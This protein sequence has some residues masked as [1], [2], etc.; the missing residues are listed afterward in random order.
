[1]RV[2]PGVS[3]PTPLNDVI[4]GYLGVISA[5]APKTKRVIM[6]GDSAG[7]NLVCACVNFLLINGLPVPDRLLLLYPALVCNINYF[8][9]SLLKSYQ[10]E[11]INFFYMQQILLLYLGGFRRNRRQEAHGPILQH[12]HFSAVHSCA[13]LG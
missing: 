4:N 8:S 9:P 7:G 6:M 2:A 10:D 3:F 5:F 13:C 1:M 12:V 11:M